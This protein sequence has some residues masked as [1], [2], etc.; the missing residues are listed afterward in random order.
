MPFTHFFITLAALGWLPI[1]GSH[2]VSKAIPID[3]R[4]LKIGVFTCLDGIC[5]IRQ[6]LAFILLSFPIETIEG[7]VIL[8][9][10]K[11]ADG[12]KRPKI[13]F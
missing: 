11:I 8:V 4:V 3:F 10:V 2:V 6:V 13:Y 7:S 9:F 1:T 5:L 12:P